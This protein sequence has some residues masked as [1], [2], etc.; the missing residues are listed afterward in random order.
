MSNTA[1]K[2]IVIALL[3]VIAI[4]LS[5]D[6]DARWRQGT[7]AQQIAETPAARAA[8]ADAAGAA[9]AP[10][11]PAPDPAPTGKV[12]ELVWTKLENGCVVNQNGTELHINGTTNQDGYN[13][14]NGVQS[15]TEYPEGDF[16][17]SAD[18]KV[19]QFTGPGGNPLVYLRA[20]GPSNSGDNNAIG[21]Y[22]V[23]TIGYRVQAWTDPQIQSTW[24]TR[25][26]DEKTVYHR[27]T[28]QY[29]VATQIATGWVDD[30]KI[31]TIK[32]PLSGK[33]HFQ[34]V[35]NTDKAGMQIDLHYDRFK[36]SPGLLGPGPAT[37]ALP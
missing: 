18:I 15:V 7:A 30:K 34:L 8:G 36:Y 21:L 25:F 23:P 9:P 12:D 6:A 10:L 2:I 32:A 14:W 29:E 17:V 24:R 35:A 33:L 13:H 19:P 20:A 22:L 3:V 37:P 31:G 28:L 26:G 16:T 27:I 4:A 5:L 11:T 1:F